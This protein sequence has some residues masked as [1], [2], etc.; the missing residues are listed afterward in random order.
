MDRLRERNLLR[1][2]ME[3]NHP[4]NRA[5]QRLDEAI[6]TTSIDGI[7]RAFIWLRR[8]ARRLF[9]PGWKPAMPGCADVML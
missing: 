7:K 1:D 6:C 4:V 8:V 3:H 5:L 9:R 2:D